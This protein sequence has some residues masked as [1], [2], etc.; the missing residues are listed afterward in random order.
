MDT[1]TNNKNKAKN[2]Q[3]DYLGLKRPPAPQL[4]P[5]TLPPQQ[6][7]QTKPGKIGK[8]RKVQDI[9]TCLVIPSTSESSW[10][11]NEGNLHLNGPRDLTE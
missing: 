7:Q 5:T 2:S 3:Q 6:K 10:V 11:C 8:N 1:K 4:P 9:L